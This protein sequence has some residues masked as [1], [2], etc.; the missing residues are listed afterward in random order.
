VGSH[1]Y[2]VAE[3]PWMSNKG[4]PLPITLYAMSMSPTRTFLVCMLS[5]ENDDAFDGIIVEFFVVEII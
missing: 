3:K 5:N 4:L 1:T 2:I